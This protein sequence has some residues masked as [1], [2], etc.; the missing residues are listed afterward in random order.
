MHIFN[1]S[2]VI[3]FKSSTSQLHLCIVYTTTSNMGYCGARWGFDQIQ[4][5]QY[6]D[7]SCNHI[8]LQ[9]V[10]DYWHIQCNIQYVGNIVTFKT[11]S[12]FPPIEAATFYQIPYKYPSFAHI[13]SSGHNIDRRIISVIYF[14]LKGFLVSYLATTFF[15]FFFFFCILV[16]WEWPS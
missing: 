2:I 12:K 15:F 14:Y 13:W 3:Y 4:L 9:K 8:S 10:G 7:I 16:Y 6:V 11:S 5:P 1:S